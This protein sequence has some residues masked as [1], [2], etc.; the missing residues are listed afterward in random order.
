MVSL[1]QLTQSLIKGDLA[2]IDVF[3]RFSSDTGHY[4]V[5]VVYSE[6]TTGSL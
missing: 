3:V 1:V 6:R 2:P 4:A 5:P